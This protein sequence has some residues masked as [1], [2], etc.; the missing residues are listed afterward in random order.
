MKMG[1]YEAATYETAVVKKSPDLSW[2]GVCAYVEVLGGAF[3]KQVAD[4]S[5]YETGAEAVVMKSVER[6]QSI[7]ADLLSRYAMF[8]SRNDSRFQVLQDSIPD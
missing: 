4:T 5:A 2:C 3:Q 6:A 7:R 8:F 1:Q